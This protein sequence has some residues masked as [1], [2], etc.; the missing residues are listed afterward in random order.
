MANY[1]DL[2][3]APVDKKENTEQNASTSE[4]AAEQK[5]AREAAY[6]LADQTALSI[7]EDGKRFSE[8]LNVQTH[9]ENYSSTNA[10]LILA[11]LPQATSLKEK[12]GWIEAGH[13]IN[14][15]EK[16][17]SII[18]PGKSYQRNDASYG[19]YYNVH[20]VYDISQTNATVPEKPSINYDERI[21]LSALISKRPVPIELSD[22]LENGAVYDHNTKKIL[23]RKG[24][25]GPDVF[26]SVALALAR[27]EMAQNK[28]EYTTDTVAFKSY[29]VSYMLSK[30]YGIDI[31]GYDFSRMP[32]ELKGM[33]EKARRAELNEIRDT[34]KAISTR[35]DKALEQTKSKDTKAQER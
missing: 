23:V 8:Y 20:S 4:W 18:K 7:S 33:D 21:L 17:I 34:F 32:E 9:F 12:S 26:R 35:M 5:A 10:L 1:D 16:P 2:F 28:D 3:K 30:K 13:S 19:N 31:T 11:Q 29:C 27:A 14:E 15:N 6:A 25:E 22:N 24:M